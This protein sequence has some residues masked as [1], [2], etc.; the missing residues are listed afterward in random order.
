MSSVQAA[1]DEAT[2]AL[3]AVDWATAVG[4]A[5]TVDKTPARVWTIEERRQGAIVYVFGG[6]SEFQ[7]ANRAGLLIERPTI[8]V[9]VM[10]HIRMTA[11]QPLAEDIAKAEAIARK[12]LQV[13]RTTA[14]ASSRFSPAGFTKFER[15]DADQMLKGEFLTTFSITL[16][17]SEAV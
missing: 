1:I 17:D 10:R 5:V 9:S 2:T 11:G 6:A 12:A 13:V 4:E 3:A 16:L 14:V 15:F 8:Y 7:L